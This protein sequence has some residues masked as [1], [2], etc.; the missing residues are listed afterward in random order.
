MCSF[1][2]VLGQTLTGPPPSPSLQAL[3]VDR[4]VLY[5]M[6]KSVKAIYTSGLGESER[7][8]LISSHNTIALPSDERSEFRAT[9]D[10]H[11]VN[12]IS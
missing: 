4:S 3:D 8:T 10:G 2:C 7:L 11:H 1:H 12:S 9:C 5:K 6:K